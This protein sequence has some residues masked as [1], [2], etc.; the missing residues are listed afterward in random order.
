MEWNRLIDIY[1]VNL[2]G[3]SIPVM[4]KM[5]IVKKDNH[6]FNSVRSL[7][8][9]ALLFMFIKSIMGGLSKGKSQMG[10]KGGGLS[11]LF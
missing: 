9:F 7:L 8:S 3:N 1:N 6:I 5:P 10:G 2:L 11:G 4:K